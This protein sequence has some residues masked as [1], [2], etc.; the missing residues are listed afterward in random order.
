MPVSLFVQIAAV[1]SL[2]DIKVASGEEQGVRQ[3]PAC[4]DNL[5]SMARIPSYIRPSFVLH[6][7]VW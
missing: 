5:L 7:N 4:G 2:V 3:F 6:N 1:R